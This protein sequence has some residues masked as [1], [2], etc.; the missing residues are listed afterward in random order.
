MIA[1]AG[2]V[3]VVVA[4][5]VA[6]AGAG[7]GAAAAAVAQVVGN[8]NHHSSPVILVD[9]QVGFPRCRHRLDRGRLIQIVAR[10]RRVSLLQKRGHIGDWSPR[11][12]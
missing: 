8:Q 5:V 6:E 11:P 2:A 3:T 4:V 1:F 12:C 7:A 9:P 10:G